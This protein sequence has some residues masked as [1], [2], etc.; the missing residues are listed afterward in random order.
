MH[1][2]V[3]TEK[4]VKNLL[5]WTHPS[6]TMLVYLFVALAWLVLLA[7]PGRYIVLALGLFE[8]SKAW[9]GVEPKRGDPAPLAIKLKNLLV[10]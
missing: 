6:K 5:N 10:R 3:P 7:I 1:P 9:I 2:G 8:F 4:A